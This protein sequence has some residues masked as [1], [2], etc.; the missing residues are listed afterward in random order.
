MRQ[1]GKILII[2]LVVF[3]TIKLVDKPKTPDY[4][5]IRVIASS[6]SDCDQMEK[7]KVVEEML[8]IIDQNNYHNKLH[9]KTVQNRIKTEIEK[10]VSL[11]NNLT[12]T[13]QTL[14]YPAK[15]F[16]D[17]LIPGGKY[18]TLIVQLGDA[19]GRNWWSIL[20]PEYYGLSYEE[21]LSFEE[22]KYKSYIYEKWI[23]GKNK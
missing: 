19:Q 14:S 11:K 9:D 10:R 22:I 20:Y 3:L 23:K 8:K 7:Y 17:K 18:E 16:G 21:R 2:G 5:R 4:P 6:N 15:T 1:V 13:Y 12:L